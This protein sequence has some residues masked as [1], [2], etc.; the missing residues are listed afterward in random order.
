MRSVLPFVALLAAC[1]REERAFSVAGASDKP[2]TAENATSFYAGEQPITAQVIDPAMPGYKETSYNISE[3]ANLYMQFNCVGCH[4][5]GGG[6]IGPA[7]ID[8]RWIYGSAPHEIAQTIVG[9]RPN[10]MPS[11][12]GKLTTG[13]LYQLVNSGRTLGERVPGDA[14]PARLD[15]MPSIPKRNLD[16]NGWPF[17]PKERP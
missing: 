15:D 17:W 9:G 4:A 7:L 2:L 14:P 16:D 8:N 11:F 1:Q 6:A 10:G 5:N 13:Q 12:R 3:G